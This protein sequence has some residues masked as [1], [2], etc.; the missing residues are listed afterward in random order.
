MKKQSLKAPVGFRKG[1]AKRLSE[2]CREIRVFA[3]NKLGAVIDGFNTI[4][5]TREKVMVIKQSKGEYNMDKIIVVE[6][7]PVTPCKKTQ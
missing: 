1:K 2:C 6:L 5:E 3:P 4:T 7:I